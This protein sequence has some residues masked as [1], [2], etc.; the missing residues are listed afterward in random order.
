MLQLQMRD[1]DGFCQTRN[2]QL[3]LKPNAKVNWMAFALAKHLTG[4][5]R[6]AVD[7]IDTYLGTLSQDSEELV[8]CYESGEL[9]L[10]KN[11]ILAE[12]P[13]NYREAL[14]HLG[15][16]EGIVVDRGA[17]LMSKAEYQLKLKDYV[18]AKQSVMAMFDRGMTENYKVHS[19]FMCILLHVDNDVC[20]E[21]LRLNGTQTLATMI[22]LADAQ[23]ETIRKVYETDLLDKYQQSPAVQR[24]PMSMMK[25]DELKAA[26][27][28]RC[29]KDLAKG[30]P[31]LC[32]ELCS[33]LW[34]DKD[35]RYV[36]PTDP[37]DVKVHP[38]YQMF[39]GVVDEY[40]A[41]LENSSKFSQHD[42][43]EA[44]PDTLLWCWYLRAGLHE[45][46]AEYS[47]GV[48]LLDKCIDHTPTEVDVYELKAR[49]LKSAGDI[50]AAVECISKGRDLDQQDRYI[51]NLTTKYMLQAG[52]EEK[53]RKTISLFAK[54]EGSPEHNLFEMQCF[55]YELEVAENLAQKEDWGRALKKYGK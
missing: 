10:Y 34:I 43:T 17:W 19:L 51:N 5:L 50:Q 53:A 13:D 11:S 1:L 35:G 42:E 52:M 49:M 40:V 6:G 47:Q 48:A 27:N 28:E 2:Q 45:M 12:I 22:P 8:R 33:L 23:K 54:H 9:A 36:R 55:W 29:R 4:D 24:I 7:V 25:V 37:V 30:V 20:N 15:A 16:V 18:A 39:V 38:F 46:V 26:V 44:S 3:L 14:L 31:S 41:S 32:S 21:A